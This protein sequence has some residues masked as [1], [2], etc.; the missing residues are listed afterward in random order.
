[1]K[2]VIIF[3]SL[4]VDGFEASEYREVKVVA[5]DCYEAEQKALSHALVKY[6]DAGGYNYVSVQGC[7]LDEST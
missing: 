4:T 2:T 5:Q 3:L 1:M 6:I 7:K